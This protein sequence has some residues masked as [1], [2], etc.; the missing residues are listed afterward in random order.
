M[1]EVVYFITHGVQSRT[2]IC[3]KKGKTSKVQPQNIGSVDWF[4]KRNTPEQLLGYPFS[5]LIGSI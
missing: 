3:E 4:S 5:N 2:N 1:A